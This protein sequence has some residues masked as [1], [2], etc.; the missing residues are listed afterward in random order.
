MEIIPSDGG[1]AP[2]FDQSWAMTVRLM[3]CLKV[4]GGNQGLR[5]RDSRFK[6]QMEIFQWSAAGG[7]WS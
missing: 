7:G 2:H 5:T 6:C 1:C 3:I 4:F